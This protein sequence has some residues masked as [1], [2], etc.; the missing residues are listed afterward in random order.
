M[1]QLIVKVEAN[2][3][4]FFAYIDELPGC[5]ATGKNLEELK[6]N[7]QEQISDHINYRS[8]ERLDIPN[9]FTGEYEMRF[10]FDLIAFLKFYN[11]VF[12]TTQLGRITG[13]NA[14]LL[15]H[16]KHELKNPR[17]KQCQKIEEKIHAFA[18]DLLKIFIAPNSL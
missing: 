18:N 12:G 8:I 11:G 14:A 17:L 1:E 2:D 10:N 9:I 5:T 4:S 7:L 15:N 3:K 16:Y 6:K 13:I